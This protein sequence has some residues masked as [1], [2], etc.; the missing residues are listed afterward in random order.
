MGRM[1]RPLVESYKRALAVDLDDGSRNLA[2]RARAWSR[3]YW[4]LAKMRPIASSMLVYLAT[5]T[6]VLTNPNSLQEHIINEMN[7][8]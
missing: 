8:P 5:N 6:S 3:E 2:D 1:M 7:K 4:Q